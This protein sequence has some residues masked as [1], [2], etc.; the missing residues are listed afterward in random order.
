MINHY[1]RRS[2]R[3]LI[4][5][6]LSM[7]APDAHTQQRSISDAEAAYLQA[8]LSL[9]KAFAA[10]VLGGLGNMWGRLVGSRCSTA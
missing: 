1:L 9:V 7:L 5:V 3:A 2:I 10:M 8:P 6:A 4:P